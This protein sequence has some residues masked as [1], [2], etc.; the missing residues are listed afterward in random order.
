MQMA[1][2]TPQRKRSDLLEAIIHWMLQS[3]YHHHTEYQI[4]SLVSN[5]TL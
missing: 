2:Y 4:H 5:I 3:I 1:V